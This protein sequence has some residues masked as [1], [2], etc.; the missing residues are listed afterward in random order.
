M[1]RV[2]GLGLMFLLSI[3]VFPGRT[4]RM[5]TYTAIHGILKPSLLRMGK[6][7]GIRMEITELGGMDMLLDL[8]AGSWMSS[9]WPD[10]WNTFW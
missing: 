7:L 8:E 1:L 6:E 10:P 9:S 4:V 3:P 5:G 2:V